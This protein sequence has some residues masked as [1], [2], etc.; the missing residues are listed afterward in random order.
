MG[1]GFLISK[2]MLRNMSHA[3]YFIHRFVA[4]IILGFLHS[5]E[6]QKTWQQNRIKIPEII[7]NTNVFG[8]C[9]FKSY[10]RTV[11][12]KSPPSKLVFYSYLLSMHQL[13]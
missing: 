8:L 10:C 13:N 9:Q 1:S 7:S 5:S 11:E 2:T 4:I 3:K 6:T 12:D